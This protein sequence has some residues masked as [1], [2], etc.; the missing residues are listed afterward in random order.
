MCFCLLSWIGRS[1]Y[2][3]E[4]VSTPLRNAEIKACSN[5]AVNETVTVE[6]N[7]SIDSQS[8]L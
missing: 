3:F 5:V 1:K 8:V 2:L 7:G 6:V 4:C